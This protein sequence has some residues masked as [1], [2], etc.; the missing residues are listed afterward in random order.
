M[1]DE[2]WSWVKPTPFSFPALVRI[3]SSGVL[4]PL[5]IRRTE[6]LTWLAHCFLACC[7]F[8]K[9]GDERTV[10]SEWHRSKSGDTRFFVRVDQKL[11]VHKRKCDL[12]ERRTMNPGYGDIFN[13]L[14]VLRHSF[15]KTDLWILNTNEKTWGK[16]IPKFGRWKTWWMWRC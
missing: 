12:R 6:R 3:G 16:K 9:A 13:P 10:P 7:V 15:F 4:W 1:H 11:I 8:L 14:A 2:N 5:A